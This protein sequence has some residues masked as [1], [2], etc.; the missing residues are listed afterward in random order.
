MNVEVVPCS[1]E[2]K[3]V[4]KNLYTHWRYNRL[5]YIE[6]GP[7]SYINDHGVID[8]DSSRTHDE[9]TQC[10]DWPWERPGVD[11]PFLI[12]ADGRLVGFVIVCG[13]GRCTRGRDWRVSDFFIANRYRRQGIGR[14][15]ALAVFDQ[16]RG[17]WEIGQLPGDPA[18]QAFWQRVVGE[19]TREK[20][21][22]VMIQDDANEPP[23]PGQNYDNTN[24]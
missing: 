5:K 12:R 1:V 17:R 19:Y 18:A 23:Y 2:Q 6:S 20:F 22:A 3:Q 8:G 16:L 13:K 9:A 24:P 14:Q 21:E 10:E 11:F 7:G 4:L 15:A